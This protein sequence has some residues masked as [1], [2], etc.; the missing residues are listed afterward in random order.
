MYIYGVYVCILLKRVFIIKSHGYYKVHGINR[1][2]I[3][4]IPRKYIC[5]RNPIYG[6][7]QPYMLLNGSAVEQ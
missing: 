6:P 2:Y 3:R 4:F 1:A 5:N 7:G